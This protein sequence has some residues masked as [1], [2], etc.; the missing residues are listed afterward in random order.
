MTALEVTDLRVQYGRGARAV[1]A[2]DGVSLA[3]PS[4]GTLGLVGESGS[5]KSTVARALVGLAHG[6]FQRLVV[7]DAE[8]SSWSRPAEAR[9]RRHVQFIT[10]D[11]SSAFNPRSTI[12]ASIA[13]VLASPVRE[14]ASG[15]AR[16]PAELLELVALDTGVARRY[17]HELSGGQLQRAS[18]AR[19]LAA[20]P[21]VLIA[22][23]ITSAL[24]V[25][26][27]AGILRLLGDLQKE[28]ALSIVF[29]S[30]NLAVTRHIS[31]QVAVM[32][33]GRIVEAGDSE[34]V[35]VQSRHPYTRALVDSVPRLKVGA[36]LRLPIQSEP[37]DPRR[38]PAG[39]RFH[40]RCPVGP[41]TNPERTDCIEHDPGTI[42]TSASDAAC[43][44]ASQATRTIAAQDTT[45]PG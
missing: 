29:I 7:A 23:E 12:G 10:Q 42:A 2:V 9:V 31:D 37:P 22:D 5:G 11:P 43:H 35:L 38:P 8:F 17:P 24:D 39:C 32:Y 25:G 44:Y 20:R 34:E 1:R 3:V 33:L 30:H 19:A 28:L 21:S 16:T 40:P 6:S 18:I 4:G 15:T 26:V 27:Q 36:P 14:S 13:E 45:V 41:Q